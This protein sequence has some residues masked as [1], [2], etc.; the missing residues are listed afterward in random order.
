MAKISYT[1]T[2]PPIKTGERELF[3]QLTKIKHQL[4]VYSEKN[5]KG[6]KEVHKLQASLS[7]MKEKIRL[8][9]GTLYP[10]THKM[11]E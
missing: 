4:N 2:L 10:D 5:I 6:K 9:E 1:S 11:N 8:Y 3:N 7:Q